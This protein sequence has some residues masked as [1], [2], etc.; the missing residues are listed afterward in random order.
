MSC[1]EAVNIET[2]NPQACGIADVALLRGARI[3]IVRTR[4]ATFEI[5]EVL[6]VGTVLGDRI[7]AD[8]PVICFSLL[9]IDERSA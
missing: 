3:G 7:M 4:E 6:V 1:T 5:V 2:Q 8:K 9:K